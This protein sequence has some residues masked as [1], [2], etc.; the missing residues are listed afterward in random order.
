MKFMKLEQALRDLSG[1][2]SQGSPMYHI[3]G[4]LEG[5]LK[6]ESLSAEDKAERIADAI[7]ERL[8]APRK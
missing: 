4:V 7:L 1:D 5:I 6:D 8:P 2:S 3:A